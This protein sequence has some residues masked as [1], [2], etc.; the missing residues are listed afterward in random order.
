MYRKDMVVV[1][2]FRGHKMKRKNI[3]SL[4]SWAC[5]HL[6]WL[7]MAFS[8]VALGKESENI[9]SL[10]LQRYVTELGLNK[11][12]TLGEFWKKNKSEFPVFMQKDLENYFK[13]NQNVAMPEVSVKNQKA[14]D[15]TDVP[16]LIVTEKG[17]TTTIQ[18]YEERD[19]WVKINGIAMTENDLESVTGLYTRLSASDIRLKNKADKY[20]TNKKNKLNNLD[21]AND[22]ARFEGFPRITPQLWKSMSKN[23]RVAYVVK[24]RML[25]LSAKKV[26]EY[27]PK[28]NKKTAEHSSDSQ[29]EKFFDIILKKAEAA[30]S[31]TAK[32]TAPPAAK[33]AKS[34]AVQVKGTTVTTKEGKT[35]RI[36]YN[37]KSCV[38]AGYVGAYS[39]TTGKCSPEVALATYEK[40]DNLKFVKKANDECSARA[41]NLVACNPILYSYPQGSPLCVDS[42]ASSY[43]IATHYEGPC[44]TASRLSSK[45]V[46]DKLTFK[47]DYSDIVPE[48][49]RWE[50]IDQ[51]QKKDEYSYTNEF[52]KGYLKRNDTESKK[53]SELFEQG[54]WDKDLDEMLVN[55]QT[56]FET[57]IERSTQ[58]C[59]EGYLSGTNEPNQKGACDQLHRRWLF[60]ER[61]IAKIRSTSCSP[62]S[63]YIGAYEND[64]SS[65]SE[66]AKEKTKL[67]KQN[68]DSTKDLLC[69]CEGS[70]KSVAF[71][72]SCEVTQREREQEV[73]CTQEGTELRTIDATETTAV[74]KE[75]FCTSDP[76][77]SGV[78]GT[79]LTC[80]AQRAASCSTKYPGATGLG[81]DCLCAS[82]GKAPKLD[83]TGSSGEAESPES[84]Q[85]AK[86]YSCES[87]TNIWPWVI[88]GVAA[89]LA[90]LFFKKKKKKQEDPPVVTPPPVV[91]P[92]TCPAPK[93]G[94]PP[95]CAC[96]GDSGC[97]PPQHSYNQT[98]CQC[99]LVPQ[100]IMCANNTPAPS[101]NANLCPKCPDGVT[102][103]SLTPCPA[104]P[105][106]G[107]GGNSCPS[108]NCSGGVPGS[109]S[110][111]GKTR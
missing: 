83:S 6:A 2:G 37:A 108:G 35:V 45:D 49:R 100:T 80:T 43:Q 73:K 95:N 52:I 10:V 86:T 84:A 38:V 85:R 96:A 69:K 72:Q 57:E 79:T 56:Q 3:F 7:T 22:L 54:K 103:L 76:S 1:I 26:S 71:G 33:P 63:K 15:G 111:S 91:P 23:D 64:E 17:K 90:F 48:A 13:E 16:V 27:F 74:K 89:L 9:N 34:A 51:D 92:G 25:W 30:P 5:A 20:L 87:S 47:S 109:G 11:K 94:T 8:P 50:M 78:P 105:G 24:M 19:K 106:E 53:Y 55:I 4:L 77:I 67:N 107:G 14:T 65:V 81:A 29:L 110:G 18:F 59:R 12:S 88:G 102:F 21:R 97:T 58:A 99:D 66:A 36:P 41:S 61:F 40:N 68:I 62:G 39:E 104:D 101:N 46:K 70:E 32:M 60:T 28:K 44:D 31:G 75:C 93:V 98:T 42:K 82:N